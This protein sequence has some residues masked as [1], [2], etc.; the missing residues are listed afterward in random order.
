MKPIRTLTWGG[1]LLLTAAFAGPREDDLAGMRLPEIELD[2]YAQTEAR[3]FEDFAG[4]A[5]L[6]EF[7]AYW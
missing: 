5:V 1:L 4:R 3:S 2:D 7:F 6:F